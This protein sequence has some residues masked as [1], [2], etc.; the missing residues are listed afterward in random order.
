MWGLCICEARARGTIT[1]H[2]GYEMTLM[3][4]DQWLGL[5]R[6]LSDLGKLDV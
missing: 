6:G 5:P 1:F 2:M 3:L 4:N